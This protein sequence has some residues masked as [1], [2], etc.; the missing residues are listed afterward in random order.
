MDLNYLIIIC[1]LIFIIFTLYFIKNKFYVS[2]NNLISIYIQGN[3][4]SGKSS[5]LNILRHNK[6][7]EIIDEPINLWEKSGALQEFYK[8]KTKR[9]YVFQSFAF[10]SRLK[11]LVKPTN[12]KIKI[13]ERSIYADKYCFAQ[14][15]YDC[16]YMDDFE[17][18]IYNLI[19]DEWI[20]FINS[21]V[22]NKGREKKIILFVNCSPQKCFERINAR[23]RKS[24]GNEIQLEY[25]IKLDNIH[26]KWKNE[27]TKSNEFIIQEIDNEININPLDNEKYEQ[28]IKE[29]INEIIKT[30]N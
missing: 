2:K 4:G 11:D 13:F 14:N 26:K 12:K 29:K 25:L 19:F 23:G 28:K 5:I 15:T 7:Y 6:D 17:W 9:G 30:N 10:I 18:K 22:N 27:L 21:F 24:E 8:N 16:G 20:N 3:I 1:A